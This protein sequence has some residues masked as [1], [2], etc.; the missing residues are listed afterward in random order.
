MQRFIKNAPLVYFTFLFVITAQ[1][2]IFV[3]LRY[4]FLV[5]SAVVWFVAH[6]VVEI[7]LTVLCFWKRKESLTA[8][9][10]S[11]IAQ[12]LPILAI[13]YYVATDYLVDGVTGV[14]L[15]LHGLFCFFSCFVLSLAYNKF[16]ILQSL[17]GILNSIL[18]LLVIGFSLL[19]MTFGQIGE[20]TVKRAVTSPME[21]YSA[22]LIS[23][24]QGALGG[25]TLV[26]VHDHTSMINI[27]IGQYVRITR[28]YAGEWNGYKSARIYWRDDH[29]LLINDVPYT[30]DAETFQRSD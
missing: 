4:R 17:F 24:D 2:V 9:S 13:V 8:K 25:S 29:T 22:F 10:S 7:L 18:L 16:N 19:F 12:L 6:I 14:L 27:G 3:L 26:D 30:I 20:H 11:I 5:S 1:T 21:S 23:S 28:I 15:P